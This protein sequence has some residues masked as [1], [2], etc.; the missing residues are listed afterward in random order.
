MQNEKLWRFKL[1]NNEAATGFGWAVRYE[2]TDLK[3]LKLFEY[4]IWACSVCRKQE[5]VDPTCGVPAAAVPA[6]LDQPRPHAFWS[7][8]NRDSVGDH[9]LRLRHDAITWH[10]RMSLRRS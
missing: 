2:V 4:L 10:T 6:H 1:L 7:R 8:I 9:K 3:I 5:L